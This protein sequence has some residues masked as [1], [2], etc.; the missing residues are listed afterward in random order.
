MASVR[1]EI[2]AWLSGRT[3]VV[4]DDGGDLAAMADRLAAVPDLG[5]AAF[6]AEILDLAR[7][8][9]ESARTATAFRA[10][11][12]TGDFDH[13]GAR[14]TVLIL[15]AAAAALS[16]GRVAWLSRPAARR[17][18]GDLVGRAQEA[19]AVA[20]GFEPDLYAWLSGLVAVA[21]RLVSAI[22]ADATPI[23]RVESGISLPSTVLAYRMYGDAT[24]AGQLV[25]IAGAGTP[26]V[27]PVAFD[28]L[29]L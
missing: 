7:I 5:A 29:A 26:M 10:L 6:A 14:E 4:V 12:V 15:S 9:G 28:A 27:M 20:R 17:A 2:T 25:D 3:A 18:R 11:L 19:Y 13:D 16:I 23:V 24:R 8:L 22:A 1:D 21:V